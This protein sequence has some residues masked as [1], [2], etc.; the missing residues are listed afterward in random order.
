[1]LTEDRGFEPG[2]RSPGGLVDPPGRGRDDGADIGPLIQ[3]KLEVPSLRDRVV[4]RPRL[5]ELIGSLVDQKRVVWVTATAGS[6]KTTAVVQALTAFARPVAWLTVTETDAEPGR[7][8]TYLN[9]AV[10]RRVPRVDG[11]VASALAG[12]LAPGEVAGLLA[13]A[14][15]TERLVVVIDDLEQ[16]AEV[17]AAKQV[18]A[19][20]ISHVPAEVRVVLISRRW[21]DVDSLRS[22]GGMMEHASVGDRDLAFRASEAADALAGVGRAE[23]DADDAVLATGGWV[24][25]VLFEAW[26][27]ESHVLGAG[28]EGDPLYG[29]LATQIL[30]QLVPADREFLILTSVLDEVSPARVA[31]IGL[32][33]AP[34]RLA[35]LRSAHLPV[36]WVQSDTFRC[37]RRLREYLS[38]LLRR[39]SGPAVQELRARYARLL[40]HEGHYEEA[41]E[42]FLSAGDL[43]GALTALGPALQPV[44]ERLELDLIERWLAS[45]AP[46][47]ARDGQAWPE[48]NLI[49]ADAELIIA[50]TKEDYRRGMRIIRELEE[51]GKRD[52]LVRGTSR[53]A[54]NVAV[55]YF[56]AADTEQ[57]RSVLEIAPSD[58]EVDAMR[59]TL[60]M[61]EGRPAVSMLVSGLP[62]HPFA[63]RVQMYCGQFA[64]L[65]P[66]E[67]GYSWSIKGCEAYQIGALRAEGR[68]SE[69]LERYQAAVASD[70][71][72]VGVGNA[73]VG[74][75]L[76][77]EVG[78]YDEALR[79]L[80]TGRNAFR[81]SGSVTLEL[82]SHVLEA[83]IRLRTNRDAIKAR[84]ALERLEHHPA[85]GRLA[86]LRELVDLWR[87]YELLLLDENAA[88]YERLTRTTSCMREGRRILE[89]PTAAVY[90]SEAAWR[91]GEV[92]AADQAMDLAYK[93]SQEQGSNHTLL[94]AVADFPETLARRL[95]LESNDNSH[96]HRVARDLQAHGMP[97]A[98]PVAARVE[99]HE[100]GCPSVEIDGEKTSPKLTKSLELLAYL[101]HC[102]ERGAARERVGR[103]LFGG[104]LDNSTRSYFRQ[105][106]QRLNEI[107]PEG[108]RLVTEG[109]RVRIDG[110]TIVSESQTL[111]AALAEASRLRGRDRLDATMRALAVVEQGG[112]L[113][114]VDSDWACERR[115]LLE[116][117]VLDARADAAELAFRCGFY[118]QAEALVRTVLE[119]DPYRES[120]W[121]TLMRI[122]GELG[123]AD[124][125][126][127]AYRYCEES[128][129]ELGLEPTDETRLQLER[130]RH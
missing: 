108:V 56:H 82:L 125:V 65:P 97:L 115:R 28:G 41:M 109:A 74:P 69:A 127:A 14:L 91:L 4:E 76:M 128:L 123:D 18:I 45:L 35:S 1:M 81:A 60:E 38:E 8:L 95:D 34:A 124:K 126:V 25:G 73:L 120:A 48:A 70:N 23:I 61:C 72:I 5:G 46:L 36:T 104:R 22:S 55:C 99:L 93:A 29:Y 54:K 7:L 27:S 112:Y 94:Q 31:A 79:L 122:N 30:E 130:L 89:L 88:A 92:D 110:A 64:L 24:T 37:H 129:R 32:P 77:L 78:H 86:W 106:I 68:I 15:R 6:G 118:Q 42:E 16:L 62:P 117:K 113:P 59:A 47:R 21:L 58:V 20:F 11:L 17:A 19:A 66:F 67:E 83:K 63:V 39:Q 107:L 84:V 12:G 53:A 57:L 50:I 114:M 75:E 103:A 51:A 102:G 26:R 44:A 105:A 2:D 85:I 87:G 13:D 71:G 119:D 96:W 90:L 9:A 10:A 40:L 49:M 33:D 100:F 116:D 3:Q 98:L 121:Q 101:A 43:D 111:E 52:A 80:K